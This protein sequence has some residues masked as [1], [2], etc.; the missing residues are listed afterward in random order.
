MAPQLFVL[1]G[2]VPEGLRLKEIETFPEMT[3]LREQTDEG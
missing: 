1:S 2:A 3:G